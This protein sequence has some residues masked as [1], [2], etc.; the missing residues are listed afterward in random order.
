MIHC[1]KCDSDD[2]RPVFR[3]KPKGQPD[4]GWTCEECIADPP[5]ADLK[6]LVDTIDDAD[7]WEPKR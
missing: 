7:V 6:E 2:G 5:D 4:A 3:T 1:I